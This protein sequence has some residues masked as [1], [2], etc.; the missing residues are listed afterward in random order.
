LLDQNFNKKISDFGLANLCSKDQSAISMTTVRGTM[1]YIAPEVFFRN[2]R[3]VSAK[4]DVYSFGILLLEIVGGKKT[5]D[6]AIENTNQ[7]NFPE[8]IYNLLEQKEDLRIFVED[9]GDAK[10]AKKL[11]IVGL[12]CI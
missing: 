4:A 10:I 8:W 9:D 2:F 7:V 6:V 5:V 12:W 1:G 11:A 3:N